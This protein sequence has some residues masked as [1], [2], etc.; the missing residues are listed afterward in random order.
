MSSS[1]QPMRQKRIFLLPNMFVFLGSLFTTFYLFQRP[2]ISVKLEAGLQDVWELCFKTACWTILFYVVINSI[3]FQMSY[4]CH[5]ISEDDNL[6]FYSLQMLLLTPP[7]WLHTEN[8]E[9]AAKHFYFQN[10]ANK[11]LSIF[12]FSIFLT[13]VSAIGQQ[14]WLFSSDHLFKLLEKLFTS[15]HFCWC[16]SAVFGIPRTF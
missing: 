6:T 3:Y 11:L 2:Y 1:S 10:T 12:Y 9:T 13:C 7:L 15:F 14:C 8:L 16:C 5:S 4:Y